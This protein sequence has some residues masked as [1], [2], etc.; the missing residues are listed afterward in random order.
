[1]TQKKSATAKVA[2]PSTEAMILAIRQATT[3]GKLHGLSTR[4]IMNKTN[5]L[6]YGKDDLDTF[7][8]NPRQEHYVTN[9]KLIYQILCTDLPLDQIS[10]F[11]L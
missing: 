4:A 9:L 2:F 11:N 6:I 3:D 7:L 10:F 8:Q 1:M 5:V